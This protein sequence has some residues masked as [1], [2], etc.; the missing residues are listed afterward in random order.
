[1]DVRIE[2]APVCML[3]NHARWWLMMLMLWL[4]RWCRVVA[5]IDVDAVLILVLMWFDVCR[6]CIVVIDDWTLMLWICALVM[7]MMWDLLVCCCVCVAM[8]VNVVFAFELLCSACVVDVWVV[9]WL[10]WLG[11]VV[12]RAAFALCVVLCVCCVVAVLRLVVCSCGYKLACA[13]SCLSTYVVIVAWFWLVG[14]TVAP[15]WGRAL[16]WR[17]CVC[18]PFLDG[19]DCACVVALVVRCF[20]YGGLLLYWQCVVFWRYSV[21]W[22]AVESGCVSVLPLMAWYCMPGVVRCR[23]VYRC[24]LLM[25]CATWWYASMRCALLTRDV[26][27]CDVLLY[28]WDVLLGDARMIMLLLLWYVIMCYGMIL[29]VGDGFSRE[30]A[31]PMRIVG[32][33]ELCFITLSCGVACCAVSPCPV[34]C[35]ACLMCVDIAL[36]CVTSYCIALKCIVS[37]VR[38]PALHWSVFGVSAVM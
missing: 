7:M 18:V 27:R 37:N 10:R 28:I 3:Y 15:V 1:M 17:I 13:W 24:C 38:R 6:G 22:H 35:R 21:Y 30:L 29:H 5:C 9:V 16:C 2:G 14:L 26:A 11:V 23:G 33:C 4:C 34:E 19:C 36:R 12:L 25:C 32:C 20:W 31:V 8:V